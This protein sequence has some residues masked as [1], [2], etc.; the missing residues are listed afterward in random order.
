[1]KARLVQAL[2]RAA[3]MFPLLQPAT[4]RASGI[5]RAAPNDDA[6]REMANARAHLAAGTSDASV[7]ALWGRLGS[8]RSVTGNVDPV[9]LRR[10]PYLAVTREVARQLTIK[11]SRRDPAFRA[12]VRS[13]DIARDTQSWRDGADAYSRALTLYPFHPGYR[14]QRGHCQKELG[15]LAAAE[16]DYR[17]ALAYGAPVD[18][19][20][21]HLM[22]V[23]TE[24]TRKQRLH[25]PRILALLEERLLGDR[26]DREDLTTSEEAASLI[27]LFHGIEAPEPAAILKL[28]RTAPLHR[29]L[30]AALID[31][32]AFYPANRVLVA[33]TGHISLS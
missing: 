22:F 4:R 28:M 16:I 27:W 21:P 15:N 10:L 23:H 14:V 8:A 20:W 24:A 7:D 26:G 9:A 31:D 19:V 6:W 33:I 13:G 12:L 5:D 17:D 32:P 29:Q 2:R 25:P 11:A 1:M 3:R 18:D 30:A